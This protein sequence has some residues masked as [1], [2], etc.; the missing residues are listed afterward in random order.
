MLLIASGIT[1][2]SKAKV[3]SAHVSMCWSLYRD[4]STSSHLG[5]CLPLQRAHS[6]MGEGGRETANSSESRQYRVMSG[7]GGAQVEEV[8]LEMPLEGIRGEELDVTL[9]A[10]ARE[11]EGVEV[12]WWLHQILW[13]RAESCCWIPGRGV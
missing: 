7:R 4:L 11:I 13:S 9:K 8:G 12:F 3:C 10:K 6:S 5:C 1:G 2:A